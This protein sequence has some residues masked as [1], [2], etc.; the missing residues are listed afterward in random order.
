[1]LSVDFLT[2]AQNELDDAFEYYEFQQENL[3]YRFVE[4]VMNSLE[5]IIAYPEAWTQSSAHTR[6]CLIKTFPYGIIYQKRDDTIIVVA[7]ASLYKEPDY[8]IA[9]N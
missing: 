1:M 3:G 2:L 6:R 5:L 8:W 4:E 9:R 7:I